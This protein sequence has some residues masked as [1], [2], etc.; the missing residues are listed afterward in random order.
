M[1]I[2]FEALS[3]QLRQAKHP[4]HVFGPLANNARAELTTR[5]RELAA[6]A[7]P[8][9]NRDGIAEATTAFQSLQ[10]WYA[11]ACRQVDQG[12]YGRNARIHAV[13]ARHTYT[14]YQEPL[15]GDLCDLFPADVDDDRV[16]L[17]VAR[18]PR[19]NDL[20]QAEA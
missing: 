10:K 6:I 14:G 3:R 9:H 12:T 4:E 5:Y 2:G 13:T 16:L 15:Q 11:D 20:L 7:H 19:N 18:S 17:K 8:D 1:Q